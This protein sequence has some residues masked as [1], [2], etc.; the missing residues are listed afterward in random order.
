MRRGSW[1]DSSWPSPDNVPGASAS[2]LP[3]AGGRRGPP[4]QLRQRLAR[5]QVGDLQV[6]APVVAV[7]I[8]L[9]QYLIP[10]WLQV[11]VAVILTWPGLS[12]NIVGKDQAVIDPELD[13]IIAADVP[14][15]RLRLR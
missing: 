5:V 7:I 14:F 8:H 9:D 13:A 6:K 3:F 12:A 4:A 11:C 2:S 10:T 15:H 1:L